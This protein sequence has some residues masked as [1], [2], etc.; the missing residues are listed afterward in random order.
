MASSGQALSAGLFLMAVHEAFNAYGALNSS[1][2]TAENFGADP[3]KAAS[4]RRYVLKATGANLVLGIGSWIVSGS[5]APFIGI[6]GVSA[7]MWW[8]YEKALEKGA[9]AGSTSWA[10]VKC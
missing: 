2:W 5:P 4:C 6:A 3:E 1:P 8:E 7:W 9:V 10:K